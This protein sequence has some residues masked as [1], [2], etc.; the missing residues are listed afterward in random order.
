MDTDT[1]FREALDACNDYHEKHGQDT[2]E[3][4]PEEDDV[5]M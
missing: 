5:P 2:Q 4:E 3:S 1:L